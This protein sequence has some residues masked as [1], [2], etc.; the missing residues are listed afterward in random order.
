MY[1]PDASARF[2]HLL[3]DVMRE[4]IEHAAEMKQFLEQW[5]AICE[6]LQMPD[7]RGSR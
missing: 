5:D 4:T 2:S 1:G 7:H 6:P 3:T